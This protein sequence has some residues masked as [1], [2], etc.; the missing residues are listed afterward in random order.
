MLL[1]LFILSVLAMA[2]PIVVYPALVIVLARL[3]P[4]RWKSGPVDLPVAHLI[5]VYNEEKVM[6]AKLENAVAVASPAGGLETVVV[7][8]GSSDRTEEIVREFEGD[9]VRWV[10]C[11]RRGKERAQ[12]DAIRTTHAPIVVFSDASTSLEPDSIRALIAPFADPAVAA[13]SGTDRLEAVGATGEDLYVSYEM[14][15]RRAESLA[16]SLV[17]L[18]GCL[19][20]VRRDICERWVPDVPNDMGSAL[21]AIATGRRAVAADDALCHYK[22]TASAAREFRR[23]RRTALRGLR[24]LLAYRSALTRGG[25]IK[26]WQVAS[27]KVMR[28]L[29]PFFALTA[30]GVAIAG[31]LAGQVWAQA[32]LVGV[33]LIG[34]C[35][36]LTIAFPSAAGLR[37]ARG[38]GFVVLSMAAVLSAW[39]ALLRKDGVAL[40]APTERS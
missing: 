23:K 2:Y 13:V 25:W 15:V 36:A 21:L 4:S 22:T 39:F 12:L 26:G 33:G 11:P 30:L 20:A 8:D 7:S 16:G 17:G 9:G 5:T 27:H 38:A 3:R 6:R 10:G 40:W 29:A 14:A 28:F 35:A 18:S 24:G 19:F 32:V 37:L 34:A 31:A 1:A